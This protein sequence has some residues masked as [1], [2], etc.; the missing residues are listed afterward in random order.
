[1]T[2]FLILCLTGFLAIFSSTLSKSPVLPLFAAHLGAGPTAIGLVAA[3]SAF[4]GIIASIPAGMLSDRW[5]RRRMLLL[6]ALVFAT[7]PPLY[8]LVSNLWQLALVRFYHGFASALF[9]PVALALIADLFPGERGERMGWFSSATLLGRFLAPLAG[10]ALLGGLAAAP[11]LSF[12]VVYGVCSLGGGAAL[13]LALRLP[14]HH[15]PAVRLRRGTAPFGAFRLVLANR[16]I[17]LTA[18]MEAAILFAFGTFETFL[19]LHAKAQGISAY[20]IGVFLSSQ[21]IVLALSRPALGRFSDR[22]GRRGQIIGGALLGAGAMAAL[23]RCSTFLPLLL[24]SALFGFSLSVLTSATAARI[25]DLSRRE[26]YGSA[27]GML[28]AVMDIGHTTG[29]LAAG[30]I[31]ATYGFGMAFVTAAGILLAAAGWFSLV[32]ATLKHQ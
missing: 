30:L 2:P 27:M 5:G 10:G 17:M 20:G 26:T 12:R 8:L 6:S 18:M 14:D 1:M 31:A 25:A 13:L 32:P 21:M 3:V 16:A 29:P 4:T 22:H 23:S 9:I 19:P 11:Y 28:G 24:T 15:D 7:A